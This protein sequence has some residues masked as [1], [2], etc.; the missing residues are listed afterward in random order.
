[1]PPIKKVGYAVVGLGAI[2]EGSVLP[3]FEHARHARLVAVV[4]R[5]RNKAMR[6]G[7]KFKARAYSSDEYEECLANPQV[8]A[9]YIATPPGEHGT[10]A[11]AA[12]RA[13]KHVLCEKPL[14]AT[15]LQSRHIVEAHR[16]AGTFLMTAYRKYFEPACLYVRHMVANGDLGRIDTIHTAFS[17]LYKP[18]RSPAWLV[19]PK[20]AGGG[21]LMDL[22][23]YCVNTVRWLID[24]DPVQVSA[25]AWRHDR[26]KFRNVEEGIQFRLEFPSGIFLQA[27]T[28]Y[29]AAL[30]SFIWIQGT[31]GWV[32]LAPAFPFDEERR[33]TGK[34]CGRSIE[35][36]FKVTDEFAAELDAFAMAIV[37][38]KPPQLD[39][40]QGHRDMLIMHATYQAARS[41]R[42]IAIRYN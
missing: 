14:A 40:I 28:T 26:K 13:G 19:D 18:G 36:H 29:S 33:L 23:V 37:Q 3:A 16:R 9:V 32:L 10:Y 21:P 20:L 7:R 39:G 31:Q 34:V 15:T 38:D 27:S 1:M 6:L 41:G 17:E 11:V 24:E 8:S 4:S 22:G 42:T 25:V 35:R 12:A 2:A 30:S 5:D